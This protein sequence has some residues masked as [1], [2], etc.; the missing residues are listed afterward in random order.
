MEF[1]VGG[2][3]ALNAAGT[4]ALRHF[5]FYMRSHRTRTE[6]ATRRR[7]GN[8]SFL[9]Q[10]M[11]VAR[12]LEHAA[13]FPESLRVPVRGVRRVPELPRRHFARTTT[14]GMEGIWMRHNVSTVSPHSCAV[15]CC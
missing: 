7:R 6:L 2:E 4:Q 13:V 3:C 8:G 11:R 10:R 14:F 15:R 5:R 9:G 12:L 1:P